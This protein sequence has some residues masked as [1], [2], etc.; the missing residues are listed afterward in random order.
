M[1][2][3]TN[4]KYESHGKTAKGGVRIVIKPIHVGHKYT[5]VR[6]TF[7]TAKLYENVQVARKKQSHMM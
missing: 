3:C 6:T 4:T 1:W 7:V 5:S 2:W